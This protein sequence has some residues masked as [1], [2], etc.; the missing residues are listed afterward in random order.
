MYESREEGGRVESRHIIRCE[1]RSH[2][3]LV[4]HAIFLL[5]IM[6]CFIQ[7]SIECTGL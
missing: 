4:E 3:Q 5:L 1:R 6:D 2:L 7:V